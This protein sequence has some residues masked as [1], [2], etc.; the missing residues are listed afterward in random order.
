M[1]GFQNVER[2]TS[3]HDALSTAAVGS[4]PASRPPRSARACRAPVCG[5]AQRSDR[6]PDGRPQCQASG[7]EQQTA[8]SDDGASAGNVSRNAIAYSAF[9]AA[10]LRV[11]TTLTPD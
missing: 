5:F 10:P 7:R 8:P 3:A 6:A 1:I 9:T 11:I 4:A 2:A